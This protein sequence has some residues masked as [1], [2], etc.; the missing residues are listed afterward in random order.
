[1]DK[2]QALRDN[3]NL[4]QYKLIASLDCW[5]KE[6]EYVRSGLNLEWWESNF[7]HFMN[8]TDMNPSI[9]MCWM[10]LTTFTICKLFL[11]KTLQINR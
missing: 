9:N 10:P 4:G 2:M 1:M 3:G 5:G 6:A 11:Y 7:T 8:T